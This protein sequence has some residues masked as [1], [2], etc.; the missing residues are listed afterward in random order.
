MA[1]INLGIAGA[2]GRM[3]AELLKALKQ[4]PF[5][6]IY[7]LC[8]LVPNSK[9]LSK[10][11][12]STKSMP[13]LMID[14]STPAAS[15]QLADFCSKNKIPVLMCTTGFSGHELRS[16]NKKLVNVPWSMVSNT[17]LGV[18]MMGE[19]LSKVS[20]LLSKD[21]K[22]KIFESHHKHKKDK[23]S[24]TAKTLKS[25]IVDNLNFKT[26]VPTESER[27]GRV[28]G[29][30][31]VSF[32]NNSE[33]ITIEHKALNRSLFAVGALKLAPS[34]LKVKKK[35]TPYEINELIEHS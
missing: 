30:H 27:R 31:R 1:K 20:S 14:F 8:Y 2:S 23:P 21:Y 11:P 28:Y 3:G 12:L 5:N 9:G 22:I 15:M 34:L 32:E 6:K 33:K 13:E 7:N 35:K 10:K 24:G 4:A 18:F 26:K 17:S 25:K 16:L 29:I 19:A